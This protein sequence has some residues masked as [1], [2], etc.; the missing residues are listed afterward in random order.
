[1]ANR[2][3]PVLI[4]TILTLLPLTV[5]EAAD[6]SYDGTGNSTEN[7]GAANH[8]F[9]RLSASA[10]SD[11]TSSLSGASRPN[12]RSAS[13]AISDQTDSE[14]NT[15]GRSDYIW[16]WGQFV[17]HDITLSPADSGENADIAVLDEA[18]VLYN[19]GSPFIPMTR[20]GFVTD[21]S[22][23]RQQ[24][25]A[26]TSFLDASNVYGSDATTAA[27]LRELSG[28]R[29]KTASGNMLPYN[30]AGLP[31]A[32]I[33]LVPENELRMAGDV[34]ANEQPGLTA[35]HTLFVREHNRLATEI[36]ATNPTWTD[37]QIYQRARKIVGAIFQSITY[38]EW[39]PA[40]LGPYAPN[41]SSLAYI[42]SVDPTISNEFAT[43]LFR[44]GHTMVSPQLMRIHADNHPDAD[45]SLDLMTA[46]FNPAVIQTADDVELILKGLA[47]QLQQNAD[48]RIIPQLRNTLFGPAGSGGM[49]LA[50]LNIQRGRDHG[51]A[52][53]NTVR[54]A[55]GLD[56]ATTWSDITSDISL[57]VAF[58]SAYSSID[59]LDLWP[60]SLAEDHLPGAAVGETIATAL[61]SEFSRL[62]VGDAFFYLWDTDLSPT[63]REE[64]TRTTLSDIIANNTGLSPQPNVFFIPHSDLAFDSLI[65]RSGTGLEINFMAEPGFRYQV[66]YGSSLAEMTTELLGETLSSGDATYMMQ[67][68]DPGAISAPSRF[69]RIIR[70]P[71]GECP[72]IP[73]SHSGSSP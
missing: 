68:L 70:T 45:A 61:A 15:G 3:L 13:N 60:A 20:T 71:A 19:A 5:V 24:L 39:L 52:D 38:N 36:A 30:A 65:L 46:F 6:R 8:P 56:P 16:Q 21:D 67:S 54:Q 73:P 37:E 34:R 50:A 66:G 44:F 51:L 17:D 55:Y 12:A 32:S 29:M 48:P 14:P 33:G 53:Y 63:L 69:Y 42:P 18:D 62:A 11:G 23:A 49:D 25:N 28:G 59:D 9:L 41:P 72:P 1:M 4:R 58:D 31:M 2:F 26:I 7:L 57:R 47:C 64:I 27:A 22:N 43:A 40:L 35:L 10:Y